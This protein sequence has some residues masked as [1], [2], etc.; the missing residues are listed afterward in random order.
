MTCAKR[1][2]R[3]APG[4]ETH[5]QLDV[6]GSHGD[7]RWA[8]CR[9]CGRWFWFVDDDSKWQ[10]VDDWELPRD[11]AERAFAGGDIA[12][13]AQL[14]VSSDL[15]R[16]P[17]WTTST[18]LLAFFRAVTPRAGDAERRRA[19]LLATASLSGRWA[20]AAK[21]LDEILGNESPEAPVLAFAFD[22]G[23]AGRAFDEGYEVGDALVLFQTSPLPALVRID[24]RGMR[25]YPCAGPIAFA[26]HAAHALLFT[27]SA[28]AGLTPCLFDAAGQLT[29]LPP[30]ST[31]STVRE[32]DDGW[33]LF[34]PDDDAPV[35]PVELRRPDGQTCETIRMAFAPRE[36]HACPPRR[37]GDGWIA[38]ACVDAHGD[39]HALTLLDGHFHPVAQSGREPHGPA[40]LIAPI[41]EGALWCETAHYPFVLERWQRRGATLE[42]TFALDV[43]GWH[44]VRGG[45]VAQPRKAGAPLLGFDDAGRERF[46]V[47]ARLVGACFTD[48]PGGLLAHD[49]TAADTIDPVTGAQVAPPLAVEDA[50]V[51][52]AHDGTAYLRDRAAL[53]VLGQART[54]VFVGENTHLETTC[55]GAALLRDA[56][57]ECLLVG[58]D[59]AIRGRFAAPGARFS[60]VGT[61]GGPYVVEHGLVDGAPGARVRIARFA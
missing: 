29:A 24:A 41:D 19:L 37:M 7:S 3:R 43:A 18:A 38:S 39:E 47:P 23:L 31:R 14:F 5:A 50:Q 8:R 56:R 32:L 4:G 54:R 25:E 10:Y 13:L 46:R 22:L 21:L 55:G 34:V 11:L 42:R 59:A 44:R 35:R 9:D 26:A 16:G 45:V 1:H 52:V 33:W 57:G 60:V 20:E 61:R 17:V 12:A 6:V 36:A 2:P 30:R 15:P 58:P 40:R 27:V 28:P 51:V 53:W 49:R 48:V